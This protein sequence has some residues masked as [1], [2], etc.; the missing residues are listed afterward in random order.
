VK[1]AEGKRSISEAVALGEEIA[2]KLKA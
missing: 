1:R 2:A